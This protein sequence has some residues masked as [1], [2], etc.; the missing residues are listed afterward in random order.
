MD[1]KITKKAEVKVG[2]PISMGAVNPLTL[3]P[4]IVKR[5]LQN[6]QYIGE[7]FT[8]K[9]LF[10]HHTAGTTAEGAISWWDRTPERIG[11]AYVIDR[12]GTIY[13]C[14]DPNYWAFHLGDSRADRMLDKMSIGIELVSAGPL[15]DGMFYP[16]WPNK[17]SGRAIPESEITKVAFR[18]EKEWHS[19]SDAQL[20]S[21]GQLIVKLKK[22]F[23]TLELPSRLPDL[24]KHDPSISKELKHGLWSHANVRKDK[25][26][27]FPQPELTKALEA[28][29][30]YLNTK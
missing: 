11:T 12:D 20:L 17:A 18:G 25:T 28:T 27:L 16:L 3:E 24:H 5:Y 26:D 30:K 19:Y 14:F 1:K 6:G 23:P 8:K 22:A 4:K 15:R 2:L 13:E 29:L 10:L 21:L 7:K 9:S